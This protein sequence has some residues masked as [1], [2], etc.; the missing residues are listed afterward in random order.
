LRA[1]LLSCTSFHEKLFH[2]LVAK[3][4]VDDPRISA[5]V[6]SLRAEVLDLLA[7]IATTL[8]TSPSCVASSSRAGDKTS[9]DGGAKSGRRASNAGDESSV[10]ATRVATEFV[11][12]MLECLDGLLENCVLLASRSVAHKMCRMFALALSFA[13]SVGDTG[14]F[15]EIGG[16]LCFVM[17]RRMDAVLA[18]PSAGALHWFFVVFNHV[19]ACRP[20]GALDACI[21]SLQTIA[22]LMSE[23]DDFLSAVLRARFVTPSSIDHRL[24]Y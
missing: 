4:A 1:A 8:L 10:N 23:R 5:D 3:D 15:N 9:N 7:W 24:N 11:R 12:T 14:L 22:N 21:T 6:E 19:K 18:C 17:A 20:V 16:E 2:R 13:V